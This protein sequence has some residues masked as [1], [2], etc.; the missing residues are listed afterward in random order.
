MPDVTLEAQ[1]AA[2]TY[3]KNI[4]EGRLDE[5]FV[6]FNCKCEVRGC[7]ESTRSQNC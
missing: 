1:T 7:N 2:S 3:L 4:I 5:L 6:I